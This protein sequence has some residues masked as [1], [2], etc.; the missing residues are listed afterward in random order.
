ME[1]ALNPAELRGLAAEILIENDREGRYT[2]P[3]KGLYPFQLGA[4]E[5]LE[6]LCDLGIRQELSLFLG[7][8]DPIILHVAPPRSLAHYLENRPGYNASAE[9]RDTFKKV[10]S[11]FKWLSELIR[12]RLKSG[13]GVSFE[14]KTNSKGWRNPMLQ[15]CFGLPDEP[16]KDIPFA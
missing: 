2:I 11:V 12:R 10:E 8:V 14:L 16:A 15:N 7:S 6:E 13:S 4:T 3:T 1:E 5:W 9:E